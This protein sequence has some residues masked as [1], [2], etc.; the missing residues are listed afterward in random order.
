MKLVPPNYAKLMSKED[1][2]QLGATTPEQDQEKREKKAEKI[3]QKECDAL[4]TRHSI[5]FLGAPMFRKS[6]L[7]RGWPDRIFVYWGKP[8]AWEF[9]VEKPGTLKGEPRPEQARMLSDLAENG[10]NISV[11]RSLEQAQRILLDAVPAGFE[12]TK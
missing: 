5:I 1:L 7:P 3:L 6:K 2:K 10:W 11:I 9:K 12:I 4:L 8:F